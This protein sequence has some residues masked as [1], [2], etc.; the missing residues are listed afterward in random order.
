MSHLVNATVAS[1][2]MSPDPKTYIDL[3][4]DKKGKAAKDSAAKPDSK[5]EAKPEAKPEKKPLT[6]DERFYA[7]DNDK[8]QKLRTDKPWTKPESSSGS[9]PM[10]KYFE[11]ISI[12][13]SAVT[14][15]MM[16]CQS[17]VDKGISKGGN[18]I[19]GE[20]SPIPSSFWFTRIM[21]YRVFCSF[22]DTLCNI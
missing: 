1:C 8:L 17:G 20:Y 6:A 16:H 14:K 18:P 22:H 19:E 12:G 4:D 2:I 15:M 9:R 5:P 11:T 10:A 3:D 7:V 13:P 21:V